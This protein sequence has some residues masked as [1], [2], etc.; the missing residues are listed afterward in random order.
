MSLAVFEDAARAHFSNPPA[1]W[2]I[3]P[4]RNNPSVWSV[5]DSHGVIIDRCL[6]QA[7]AQE[8]R[9]SGP[10]ATHWYQR[11]DWYLGYD[12][13]SRP[14]TSSE[15]LIIAD[16]AEMITA[17]GEAFRNATVIQAVRFAD[18]DPDDERTWEAT[19]LPNGRYQLRGHYFHTYAAA[20][21]CFVD[22]DAIT[23]LAAF[24]RDL[25]HA[26]ATCCSA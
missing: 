7:H 18:Q 17:A 20:E 14:L 12:P 1:A 9:H 3:Q 16:I 24:L 21:L 22:P 6:T 15:R 5:V 13:H 11:T 8:C 10:A 4:A 2:R 26:D 25:L 23:D 19:L